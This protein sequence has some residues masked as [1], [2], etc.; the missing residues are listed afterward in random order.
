MGP[1]FAQHYEYRAAGEL[2]ARRSEPL[3]DGFVRERVTLP[4]L[5]AP[6]LIG[7]LDAW[8]PTLYAISAP[9]PIATISFVGE[10]LVD[11]AT[12]DPAEPFRYRA[13]M[14][15][16]HDGFFVEMRELWSG[17]RVVALNQ[18]TFAVLK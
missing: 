8:W 11:P 13:R 14:A 17:A 10:I 5:D 2:F 7:R 16:L 9:R 6:A 1:A 3:I 18:Q 12:L 4:K 15:A